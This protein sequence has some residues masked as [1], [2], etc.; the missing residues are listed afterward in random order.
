M[1]NRIFYIFTL[2]FAALTIFS[3]FNA[4][5]LVGDYLYGWGSSYLF[6]Y[7]HDV[8]VDASGNVYVLKPCA[9]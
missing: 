7:P 9:K 5:A 4:D 8:A 1:K 3:S 2:L 6:Y